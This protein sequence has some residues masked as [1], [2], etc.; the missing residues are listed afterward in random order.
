[1]LL[2]ANQGNSMKQ[3]VENLFNKYPSVPI[4][5]MGIPSD[6]NGDLMDWKKEPLWN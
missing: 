3:K 4:Q 5:F 1:M 6:R 2:R